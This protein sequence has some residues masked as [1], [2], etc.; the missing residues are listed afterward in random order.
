MTNVGLPVLLLSILL[1]CAKSSEPT[2][3]NKVTADGYA[4]NVFECDRSL[5]PLSSENR[6]RK[7]PGSSY[8]LCFQPNENA[9]EDGVGIESVDFFTWELNHRE[10]VTEQKAVVNGNGD[11]ILSVLTCQEDKKLCY[12]DSMLITAFYV[13]SGSVLG[14][15]VATLTANKGQVEMERF[16]FPHDF[17]FTMVNADGSELNDEQVNDLMQRMAAQEASAESSLGSEL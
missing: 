17:K 15:G 1:I 3:A 8:R 5:K 4:V 7:I 13:D 11:N 6:Q 14:Y 12:L 2:G 10:G 9:L 16:L